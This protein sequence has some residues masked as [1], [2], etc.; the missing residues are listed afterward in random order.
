[1]QA[2]TAD[3]V[4]CSAAAQTITTSAPTQTRTYGKWEAGSLVEPLQITLPVTTSSIKAEIHSGSST[5]SSSSI[6]SKTPSS[7]TAKK[8]S[9]STKSNKNINECILNLHQQHQ[10][11]IT[12]CEITKVEPIT[13]TATGCSRTL[14]LTWNQALQ[15]LQTINPG[16][17]AHQST[18]HHHHLPTT[19]LLQIKREPC[20]V[21]E[22]TTSN[23]L[24][25]TTSFSGAPALIKIE[26]K[27]PTTTTSSSLS[28]VPVTSSTS[29]NMEI[30]THHTQNMG[31]QNNG[32]LMCLMGWCYCHEN[33]IITQ[34]QKNIHLLF[35]WQL[36]LL[37]VIL[38]FFYIHGNIHTYTAG[39]AIPIGIAVGRQRLQETTQTTNT[40][41]PQLQPKD[42]NRFNLGLTDLGELYSYDVKQPSFFI[43]A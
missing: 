19:H 7:S 27:S 30:Q 15:Q 12:P 25:A 8:S 36:S 5:S 2:H 29:A 10:T 35:S 32:K 28:T 16:N 9:K 22:V 43:W 42:L 34:V 18:D 14:P 17:Y 38:S 31:Q 24:I 41:I 33:K 40:T 20:Q 3:I 26:Q 23:N 6:S 11:K 13:P 37:I 21:S 1:M 39:A 4:N